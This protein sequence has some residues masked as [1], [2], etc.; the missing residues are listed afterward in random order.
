MVGRARWLTVLAGIS[1]VAL[2][3]GVPASAEVNP[4]PID[5]AHNVNDAPAP[6]PSAAFDMP[7]TPSRAGV[8]ICTTATSNDAN[9]NTDCNDNGTAGPHNETS[10]AV[11]P[12]DPLNIIGGANDYQLVINPGGHIS[13][14]ILSRAHVTFDGGKTWSMYGVFSNS[15]YQ[16][17]GDPSL[18]FDADGHAYYGTLGFRFVSPSNA[19]NPDVLVSNSGDKGKSW[20]EVRIAAGSGVETSVGDLLDKEYVAAW[21]HGNAIVTFG[22]FKLGQKGSLIGSTILASVTHDSGAHWTKP[23]VISGGDNEAFVSTPVIN[24]G[25]ILVSYLNTRNLTNGRDDVRVVEVSPTTGAALGAPVTVATEIPDGFTDY[26]IAFFRQTYHDSVF[27]T[28]AA[29]NLVADPTTPGHL[30]MVWSDMR[31]SE[32]PSPSN[33]YEAGAYTNSDVIVSQS[34]DYGAHWTTPAAIT[35]SGD[36]FMPWGAYDTNGL[37]RIGF[38]DRSA[39]S[40]N[41]LYNY[42]LATEKSAGSLTFNFSTVTTVA[43]DP[44]TN[45]R[46]FGRTVNSNFPHATAFLGDYSNVAA[47]PGGGVVAYWTDMRTPATFAGV[48]RQ[49]EDAYFASVG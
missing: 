7:T 1:A 5:F 23:V 44:T 37:L 35:L 13:E 26:P 41:H 48:T 32:I 8:A 31:N 3:Q 46:W 17:T 15:T 45:D 10:I 30:A 12:T 21:G 24:N 39:D 28:W 19:Q 42:S 40:A 43:S 36:Q 38:F 14:S 16:A 25:R 18:A 49:G 9:V 20:T 33:P 29:G 2:A 34:T 22:D 47:L 11:N 4:Q 6:V 27:R